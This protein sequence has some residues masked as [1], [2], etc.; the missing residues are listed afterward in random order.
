MRKVARYQRWVAK[1][2]ELW[3]LADKKAWKKLEQIIIKKAVGRVKA[4]FNGQEGE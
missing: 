2:N 3:K 1:K 4:Q